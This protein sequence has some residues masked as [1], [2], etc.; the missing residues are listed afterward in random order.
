MAEEAKK[1][2]MTQVD[3]ALK[4]V[5]IESD[6][7]TVIQVLGGLLKA[8]GIDPSEFKKGENGSDI[9]QKLPLILGKLTREMAMGTFDTNAFAKVQA[10]VPIIEKYQ[11]LVADIEIENL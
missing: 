4:C 8:F 6:V 5:E 11:Y 9:T 1:E 2:E 3:Y 7:K 10:I